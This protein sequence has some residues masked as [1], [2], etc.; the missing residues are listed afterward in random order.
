MILSLYQ[1]DFIHAAG[2]LRL[3]DYGEK[4]TAEIDLKAT[5]P[6]DTYA[7]INAPWGESAA[8]GGAMVDFTLGVIRD[9]ASHEALRAHC[10]WRCASMPNGKTGTLAISING[11]GS[12]QMASVSILTATTVPRVPSATFE[13]LT[14]LTLSGGKLLPTSA[15][16]LYAGIPCEYILQSW[17]SLTG[18]W[19]SY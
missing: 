5:Q 17:S 10:F 18:T 13:T 3:V 11:G 14:T 4:L 2:T 15:I 1:I 6:A 16:D 12:W 9:H 19:S 8:R 7:P